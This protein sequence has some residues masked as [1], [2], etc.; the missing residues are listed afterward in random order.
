MGRAVELARQIAQLAQPE[1]VLY[2]GEISTVKSSPTFDLKDIGHHAIPK[3]GD[4]LIRLFEVQH[5]VTP[6]VSTRA[7]GVDD[8]T[9][10]F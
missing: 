1:H 8:P 4:D 10:A 2:S 5:L 6:S 9:E 7:I 3:Y